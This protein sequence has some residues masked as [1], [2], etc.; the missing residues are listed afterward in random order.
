MNPEYQPI[1]AG[2]GRWLGAPPME[3]LEDSIFVEAME[4]EP[5]FNASPYKILRLYPLYCSLKKVT[6]VN[7]FLS[8]MSHINKSIQP[9]KEIVRTLGFS[10][11]VS[12][13]DLR[14]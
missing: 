13:W 3:F 9:E 5:L 12:S 1:K 10:W 8:P 7:L 11:L 2:L 14:F 6:C 4:T